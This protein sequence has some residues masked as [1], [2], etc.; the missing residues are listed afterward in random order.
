[1]FLKFLNAKA[2]E[3]VRHKSAQQ[4]LKNTKTHVL[5]GR[6][7]KTSQDTPSFYRAKE[8]PAVHLVWLSI[9]NIGTSSMFRLG[10]TPASENPPKE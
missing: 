5:Q 6:E 1:M 2:L 4:K 3:V 10:R 8:K 7:Y 9:P